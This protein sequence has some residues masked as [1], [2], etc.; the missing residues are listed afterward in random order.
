MEGDAAITHDKILAGDNEAMHVCV[1]EGKAIE[2]S[3]LLSVDNINLAFIVH[4]GPIGDL[5][6]NPLPLP[7]TLRLSPEPTPCIIFKVYEMQIPKMACVKSMRGV[8]NPSLE[9]CILEYFVICCLFLFLVCVCVRSHFG[10]SAAVQ[11]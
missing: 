6:L 5:V 4:K 7:L 11:V 2:G 1:L 10:S 9:Q 8:Q 3:V